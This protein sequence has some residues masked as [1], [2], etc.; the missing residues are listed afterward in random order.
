LKGAVSAEIDDAISGRVNAVFPASPKI[1]FHQLGV[2]AA[3]NA[4]TAV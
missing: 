2:V 3:Q 4:P 1:P